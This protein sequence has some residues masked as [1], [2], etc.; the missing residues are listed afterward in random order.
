MLAQTQRLRKARDIQRVYQKGHRGGGADLHAKAVAN[1]L[2]QNRA[3][4]V[5]SKKVSKG[6]VVRNRAKR[7]VSDIVSGLWP[8]LSLGYDIVITLHSDLV[9][10]PPAELT[11]QVSSS[12]KS[13]GLIKD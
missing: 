13:A 11:K 5:I 3:T 7:R 8:K 1:G 4:I 6:A 12:L 2:G 10:L 9:A